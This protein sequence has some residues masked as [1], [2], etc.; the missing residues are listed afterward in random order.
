LDNFLTLF[1]EVVMLKY[2]K[3]YVEHYDLI[4]IVFIFLPYRTY[5]FILLFV[6]YNILVFKKFI[7][8]YNN[9][10]VY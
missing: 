6:S 2:E 5:F 3:T 8:V 10:Y 4:F 7:L 9:T 1:E